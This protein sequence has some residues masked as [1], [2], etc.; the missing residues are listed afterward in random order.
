M[1]VRPRALSENSMRKLV[2]GA[3]LALLIAPVLAADAVPNWAFFI[4]DE[5]QPQVPAMTGPQRVEGS[6]R[7]YTRA[8]IDDLKNAVDWFPDQHAPAP[9]VVMQGGNGMV[10]ACGVCHLMSGMGHPE[11]ASLA[12]LPAAYMDRQIADFKSGARRN[13]IMVNGQPQVNAT[14]YMVVIARELSDADS[15]AAA[16]WFASLRP[17]QWVKVEETANVPRTYISRGFARLRHPAGGTEPIGNRVIEVPEDET[18]DLLRDPRSG[19]IAYVP[20][21]SI[22]AGQALAT[23]GGGGKTIQCSICHGPQ[24]RGIG[25]VPSIAGRSPTYTFRQLYSFKDGSRGGNS[26]ALMLGVVAQLNQADMVALA[27]YAA[28]LPP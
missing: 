10:L 18:R 17:L 13:P 2:Y 7:T 23:T 3:A 25:N 20:P 21:G 27:A 12:G 5:A 15:K 14:Q 6:A 9:R 19:T 16:E 24:L 26:A 1:L 4:P 28:T 22:A 8:Q 11:S